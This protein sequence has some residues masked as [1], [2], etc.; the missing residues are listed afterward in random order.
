MFL[1]T[2]ENAYGDIDNLETKLTSNDVCKSLFFNS[3]SIDEIHEI[4]SNLKNSKSTGLDGLS[5]DLYK[6]CIN[7][8]DNILSYYINS[9]IDSGI[10]PNRL[11]IARIIPIYK[12]IGS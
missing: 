3:V 8:F 10:F 1:I 4:I 12:K 11:K 6:L 9:I 2:I 5:T 7:P